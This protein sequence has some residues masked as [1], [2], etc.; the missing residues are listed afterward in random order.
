MAP[1]SNIRSVRSQSSFDWADCSFTPSRSAD[2][3]VACALTARASS[4]ARSAPFFTTEPRSTKVFSTFPEAPAATSAS[5]APISVPDSVTTRGVLSSFTG[6]SATATGGASASMALAGVG[7]FLH[8][9]AIPP[10]T[11]AA[12]NVQSVILG[13]CSC[14]LSPLGPAAA[15]G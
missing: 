13:M 11:S 2:A 10:A 8:P 3:W 9:V 15:I 6:T 14:P 5:S 1:F 4:L 7:V 12:V